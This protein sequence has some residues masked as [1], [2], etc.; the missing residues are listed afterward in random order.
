M[1]GI[2]YHRW[3]MC[4]DSSWSSRLESMGGIS[5]ISYPAVVSNKSGRLEVFSRWGNKIHHVW[6]SYK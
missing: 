5:E 2:V 6:D 1:G 4:A 3:H